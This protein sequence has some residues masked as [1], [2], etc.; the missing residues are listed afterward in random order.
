MSE[1]LSEVI[2]YSKLQ[3]Y[4]FDTVLNFILNSIYAYFMQYANV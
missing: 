1:E 2:F 3:I 4:D